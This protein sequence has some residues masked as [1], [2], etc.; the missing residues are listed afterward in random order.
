METGSYITVKWRCMSGDCPQKY[1]SS[2]SMS[3]TIEAWLQNNP[4]HVMPTARAERLIVTGT[5]VQ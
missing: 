4:K 2:T 5:D 1:L 3:A